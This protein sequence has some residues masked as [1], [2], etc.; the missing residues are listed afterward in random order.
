MSRPEPRMVEFN[1][2]PIAAYVLARRARISTDVLWSRWIHG[3]RGTNLIRPVRS[4]PPRR[5]K[6]SDTPRPTSGE[7][8]QPVSK[9][10][11]AVPFETVIR[12]WN[13]AVFNQEAA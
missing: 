12:R 4:R 10:K 7:A 9:I 3:I 2:K 5:P 11:P 1:G 13:Q 6:A 8:I